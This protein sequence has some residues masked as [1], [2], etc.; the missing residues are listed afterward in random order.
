[1]LLSYIFII[2]KQLKKPNNKDKNLKANIYYIA[3]KSI[4]YYT[5]SK[6]LSIDYEKFEILIISYSISW[7]HKR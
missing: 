6:F 5:Y 1:M 4:L 7:I 2:C 3:F